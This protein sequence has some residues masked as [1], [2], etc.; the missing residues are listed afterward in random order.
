MLWVCLFRPNCHLK[1]PLIRD[2]GYIHD[3]GCCLECISFRL[4]F[5][6]SINV[7]KLKL[8]LMSIKL[9]SATYT[10][11]CRRVAFIIGMIAQSDTVYNLDK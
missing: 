11:L 4:N 5:E 3:A 6:L 8:S 1:G 2:K 9:T 7:I 10:Q